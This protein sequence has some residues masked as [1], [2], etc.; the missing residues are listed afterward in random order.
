MFSLIILVILALMFAFFATE[1]TL[2]TTITLAGSILT[3]IPLYILIGLTLLIGLSLSWLIS[4]LDSLAVS[5]KLRSKDHT[6]SN[7]KD[8]IQDLNRKIK[9]LEIENAR[10]SQKAADKYNE[11]R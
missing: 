6:I 10:L 4:L 3:Q 11:G 8:T 5:M 2:P 7:A 1:N 9:D